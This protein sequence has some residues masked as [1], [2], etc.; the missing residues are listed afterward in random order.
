M[1]LLMTIIIWF[2]VLV[3]VLA[4]A[5]L[6]LYFALSLFYAARK[7]TLLDVDSTIPANN[8]PLMRPLPLKSKNQSGW[9][10]RLLVY[11]YI[12]REWELLQS[13][14]WTYIENSGRPDE[15]Q[16]RLVL[17]KGF[18]CDVASI[19]RPFRALFNPSGLLLLPALL[20]DYAFEYN[21]LWQ[22]DADGNYIP[23]TWPEYY[24]DREQKRFWDDLLY[25]AGEQINGVGLVNS[26]ILF[27]GRIGLS[28]PTWKM[29]RKIDRKP[30]RADLEG[31]CLCKSA[32]ITEGTEGTE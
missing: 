14:H 8:M 10:N 1:E 3:G 4:I 30:D 21:Q 2:L 17:P 25:A 27:L 20:H 19:P 23:Y 5:L 6:L 15:R 18:R 9:F 22:I 32:L 12:P 11:L 7:T 13:W 31:D 24:D 26:V 28:Q 16:I 29:Y